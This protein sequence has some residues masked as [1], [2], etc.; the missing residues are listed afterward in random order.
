MRYDRA[1]VLSHRGFWVLAGLGA[2]GSLAPGAEPLGLSFL[3]GLLLGLLNVRMLTSAL[4][5]GLR[6]RHR[7]ASSALSTAGILRL[8][9]V[10][11]V[12][13][14]LLTARTAVRPWPLLIGFFLPEAIF[15][16]GLL[17]LKRPYDPTPGHEG[18][19]A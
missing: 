4:K 8:V 9:L 14:W 6:I 11:G 17:F 15:I 10:V 19:V 13:A 3:V 12:M 2:A 7:A 18:D 1:S 5:R 16:A